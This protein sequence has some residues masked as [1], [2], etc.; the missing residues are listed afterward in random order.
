VRHERRLRVARIVAAVATLVVAATL[1]Y[2]F[3]VPD[4]IEEP[5]FLHL[6]HAGQSRADVER[7]AAQF[8]HRFAN[9][10]DGVGSVAFTMVRT[11]CSARSSRVV[12]FF[13]R[14]DRVRHWTTLDEYLACS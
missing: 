5:I 14:N 10:T 7:L 13:D 1:F 4:R 3:D 11:S 8:G 12:V 2:V 9:A 6:L